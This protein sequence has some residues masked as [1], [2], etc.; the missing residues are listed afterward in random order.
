[1]V[2]LRRM[3]IPDVARGSRNAPGISHLAG[4]LQLPP[5]ALQ[6]LR[7]V[8]L[9]ETNEPD[10]SGSGSD[11]FAALPRLGERLLQCTDLLA[12]GSR[13]LFLQVAHGAG[14]RPERFW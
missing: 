11:P 3:N 5:P 14:L 10:P 12:C 6:C 4:N 13:W 8:T 2:A 9:C 7:V 1:M